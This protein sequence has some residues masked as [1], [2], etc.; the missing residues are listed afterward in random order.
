MKRVIIIGCP[1]AGKSTFAKE[2]H[3]LTALPLYH[4]DLLY[5]NRDRTTVSKECFIERLKNVIEQ[6][7]WIIDGNYGSTIELRMKECD[8]VFFLDYPVEVCLDGIK[9]RQ[10]KPRSDMPWIET[11]DDEEFLRFIRS[12]EA[13]SKPVVVSLLKKYSDKNIV[14]FNGRK[15]AENFLDEMRNRI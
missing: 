7:K 2:L 10:G 14:I 6:E 9:E 13:E 4:L 1:G 11:E 8:T 5:W 12:Y 15:D 3:K